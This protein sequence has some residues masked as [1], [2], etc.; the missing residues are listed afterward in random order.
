MHAARNLPYAR[1][2]ELL[3]LESDVR[4]DLGIVAHKKRAFWR[5]EQ[6]KRMEGG[7]RERNSKALDR[8]RARA[9]RRSFFRPG[10]AIPCRV[11]RQQS[12]TPF[13]QANKYGIQLAART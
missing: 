9:L 11:A 2:P 8:K 4:A 7:G 6:D 5:H 10:P 1:C 12:S 3:G 13:H